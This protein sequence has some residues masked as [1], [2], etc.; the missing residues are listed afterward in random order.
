MLKQFKTM[1]LEIRTVPDPILRQ[2]SKP[3]K[4]LSAGGNKKI[5]KLAQKMIDLIKTGPE[6]KRIGVGLS[7][8]QVG[9]PIRLFVAYSKKSQKDLIFVNPK[10]IWKSKKT[11]NGIP[12][13]KNKHEGCLS[14]P[15]Y[16]GLVKRHQSIKLQYQTLNNQTFKRKFSGFLATVIQHEMD[17]L[18]GI[19][20]VD[21]VLK[22]K[23]KLYKLEK[24][25][26]GEEI[27]VPFKY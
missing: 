26:E 25:K 17:H 23:S 8:V 3:V 16:L 15:G 5:Q 21:R 12:D 27:L 20:F 11:V 7:A 14:V 9:K 2:K 22:Q 1:K 13:K 19:L 18:D 24:N 6:G 4:N 10:I